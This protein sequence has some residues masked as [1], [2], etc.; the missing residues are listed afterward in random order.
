MIYHIELLETAIADL[1]ESYDWYEE[2]STGL[3]GRFAEEVDQYLDLVAKNPYH[4][5]VQ[6]SEKFRFALL[7]RFPFRIVYSIDEQQRV[8]YVNAIFHTSRDPK[9]F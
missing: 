1:Q 9:L 4:F 3:G 6:F 2:K 8:I 5:A 7:R